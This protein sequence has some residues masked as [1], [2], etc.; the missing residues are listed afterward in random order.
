MEGTPAPAFLRA[1]NAT[2]TAWTSSLLE[3]RNSKTGVGELLNKIR[4][5]RQAKDPILPDLSLLSLLLQHLIAVFQVQDTVVT[6]SRTPE[7]RC[8]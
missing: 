7:S 8:L 4:G 6:A 5:T 3:Y 1:V 2:A